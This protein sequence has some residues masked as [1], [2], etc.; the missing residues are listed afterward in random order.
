MHPLMA[1]TLVAER[2]R[3]L[4]HRADAARQA[5]EARRGR[6]SAPRRAPAHAS[7]IRILAVLSRTSSGHPRPAR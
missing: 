3:D 6:P 2:V 4:Q 1:E 5:A 7:P